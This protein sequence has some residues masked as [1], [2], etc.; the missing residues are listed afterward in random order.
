MR[1]ERKLQRLTL[2]EVS[3]KTGIAKT[4]LSK[5]ENGKQNIT[6]GTM[7]KISKALGCQL[8]ALMKNDLKPDE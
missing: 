5:I 2:D 7:E 3:R 6:V 4:Y 1:K 8:A